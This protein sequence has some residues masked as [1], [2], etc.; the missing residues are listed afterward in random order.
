MNQTLADTLNSHMQPDGTLNMRKVIATLEAYYKV[1]TLD[2]IFTGGSVAHDEAVE[3]YEIAAQWNKD[4]KA[5]QQTEQPARRGI[6]PFM[7]TLP[8]LAT[9]GSLL[10]IAASVI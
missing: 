6:R 1:D 5:A 9:L 7:F 4:V 2:A 10:A 8:T 3:A